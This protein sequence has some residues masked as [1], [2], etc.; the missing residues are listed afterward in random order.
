MYES[1][2]SENSRPCNIFVVD[3]FIAKLCQAHTT[4]VAPCVISGPRLT[5]ILGGSFLL[6]LW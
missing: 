3:V 1:L 2:Q 6:C 4:K 5:L